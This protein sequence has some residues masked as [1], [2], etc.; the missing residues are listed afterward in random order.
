VTGPAVAD[1]LAVIDAERRAAG[2]ATGRGGVVREHVAGGSECRIVYS[3]LSAEEADDVVREEVTLA[4]DRGYALEWKL[5]GH[6]LPADLPERLVAADFEA[7]DRE[8]VLALP[9]DEAALA[10]FPVPL[11]CEIRRVG[12]AGLADSAEIAREIARRNPDEERVELAYLLRNAPDA[13][14]VYVAYVGG[15]PVTGGRVHYREGGCCAELAGGRTKTTHRRQGLFSAVVG[16]RLREARARGRELAFTDALPTS[17]PILTRLGFRRV[18]STTPY[19]YHP[20][21]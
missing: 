2:E 4:R 9:L 6:D 17:E 18:I 11:G 5:Y 1:L 7:D 20:A 16:A 14:S 13:I 21:S 15:E 8:Q 19:L 12:E 10:A 3:R